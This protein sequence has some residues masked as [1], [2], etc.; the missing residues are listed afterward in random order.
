MILKIL[1]LAVLAVF[2]CAEQV[3]YDGYS[4]YKVHANDE[5]QVQFLK[6]LEDEELHIWKVPSDVGDYASVVAPPESKE[7][8][9]H[10][11]QKRNIYSELML[12]NIQE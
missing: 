6:E 1:P 5:E 7:E 9:V 11:L 2:V 4:L 3:K 10:K 8:F 12:E